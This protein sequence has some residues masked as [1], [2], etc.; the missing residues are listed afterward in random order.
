LI[1]F[2]LDILS[3]KNN[4]YNEIIK[5]KNNPIEIYNLK[6][7]I[8]NLKQ[9]NKSIK[10]NLISKYENGIIVRNNLNYDCEF[11]FKSYTQYPRKK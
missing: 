2:K 3:E 5:L 7:K 9:E 11:N 10:E 6:N 8:Q 1:N 4:E